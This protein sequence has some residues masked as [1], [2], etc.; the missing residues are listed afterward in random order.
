DV[1]SNVDLDA[2]KLDQLARERPTGVL[3]IYVGGTQ[4]KSRLKIIAQRRIVEFCEKPERGVI[5]YVS[6]GI[7]MLPPETLSLINTGDDFGHNVFPEMI[8]HGYP[9][10]A[11][12]ERDAK[13]IDAG[14]PEKLDEAAKLVDAGEL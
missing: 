3:S 14:S 8:R 6:S 10:I 12:Y 7:Y 11:H 4:G 9:L 13:I 2:M 5:G 1:V